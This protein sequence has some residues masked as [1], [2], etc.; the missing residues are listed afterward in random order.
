M[1]PGGTAFT[2]SCTVVWSPEPS[3]ATTIVARVAAVAAGVMVAIT[4]RAITGGSNRS[5]MGAAL[6][7]CGNRLHETFAQT[8]H[9]VNDLQ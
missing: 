2:A 6:T 3:A 5:R 8:P 7:E 4:V 9:F 1:L